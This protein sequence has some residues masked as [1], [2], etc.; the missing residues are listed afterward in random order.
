M[1][2]DQGILFTHF[3]GESK[4]VTE[5][6][7]EPPPLVDP[8]GTIFSPRKDVNDTKGITE[9]LALDP[10]TRDISLVGFRNGKVWNTIYHGRDVFD[11]VCLEGTGFILSSLSNHKKELKLRPNPNGISLHS[12]DGILHDESNDHFFVTDSNAYLG[13]FPG[14]TRIKTYNGKTYG[15]CILSNKGY[16]QGYAIFEF[17]KEGPLEIRKASKELELGFFNGRLLYVERGG[18][19]I[20]DVDNGETVMKVHPRVPKLTRT[21]DVQGAYSSSWEDSFIPCNDFL[22]LDNETI[23]YTSAAVVQ[24]CE[25]GG[26][27]IHRLNIERNG[28]AKA[29]TEYGSIGNLTSVPLSF[30]ESLKK[31]RESVKIGEALDSFRY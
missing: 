18:A 22:V 21:S 23:V 2:I 26:G 31:Y 6:A 20:K 25:A 14:H 19:T 12:I 27:P 29:L 17:G 30:I 3:V 15:V 8:V 24:T 13:D 28:R 11:A 9:I 5:T 1:P 10:N 16:I 4:H 7:L